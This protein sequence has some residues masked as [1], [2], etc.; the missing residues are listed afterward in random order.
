MIT[1]DGTT[2]LQPALAALCSCSIKSQG[3]IAKLIKQAKEGLGI[4]PVFDKTGRISPHLSPQQRLAI[5]QWHC[6]KLKRVDAHLDI[7]NTVT[8][9]IFQ[10][11]E[12]LEQPITEQVETIANNNDVEIN[13]Q[14][15]DEFIEDSCH[16]D[17]HAPIEQVEVLPQ[18]NNESVEIMQRLADNAMFK[19]AFYTSTYGVKNRQVIGFAWLLCERAPISHWH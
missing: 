15:T 18:V 13:L 8:V 16:T 11:S 14:T 1:Y 19:F 6:D 17:V 5:W 3:K 7:D 10:Q 4:A 12:L 9:D 2:N